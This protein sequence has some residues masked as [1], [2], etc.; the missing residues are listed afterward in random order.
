MRVIPELVRTHRVVAPDLPGHGASEVAAGQL[1]ADHV[2][3][4]LGELIEHT[5]P[6]PPALVGRGLGGAIAAR[7]AIAHPDRLSGLVLVDAFGLSPFEPVPSFGLALNRF[8]EQPTERTRDGLFEQCF[9]DLDG[10][11]Q[12]VGERWELLAAYALDRAGTPG[13]KA[14]LGSLMPQFGL[15]AIPPAELERIALTTNLVGGDRT[16]RCGC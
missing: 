2:L 9:V 6:S 11:R 16:T 10:L 13:Q 3:G 15:P 12:Q 8:L 5:C 14:A 1:D 7:F 4:W